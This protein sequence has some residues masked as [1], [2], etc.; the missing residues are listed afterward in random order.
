[1]PKVL[2]IGV[3]VI[4]LFLGLAG[5]GVVGVK[6]SLERPEYCATC[7][8][9]P[10]YASWNDSGHL[11]RTHAVAA[12]PCQTCHRRSLATSL[13]EIV[14]EIKGDYQL[15]R[16]RVSKDVCLRCHVHGDYSELIELTKDIKVNPHEP[17]HYGEMDCAICHKMHKP[18]EDYCS[19][20]HE[21]TASGEG[22]IVKKGKPRPL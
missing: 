9:D 22:W 20:C 18:S 11:A 7:H 21:P 13:E 8:A 3:A 1:M 14:T 2:K 15:R 10:H 19:N 4:V 5:V 12:I 6:D 17:H 16:I